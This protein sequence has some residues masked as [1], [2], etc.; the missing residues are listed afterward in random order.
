MP[1][2][3]SST[4]T[5]DA[6]AAGRAGRRA[7]RSGSAP[8]GIER[9]RAAAP[10]SRRI[11]AGQLEDR[12][13]QL[14][15]GL[16]R[17]DRA[18]RPDAAARLQAL[19]RRGPR[20]LGLVRGAA[21][22]QAVRQPDGAHSTSG[23]SRRCPGLAEADRRVWRYVFIYPNTDDRPLSGPGQRSGRSIPTARSR[24]A[25]TALALLPRPTRRC[26][27]RARPAGQP[28]GQRAGRA[29]RTSTWSANVQAGI[30][31]RGWEPG[32]AV[33]ARGRGR[34]V[35]RPH[36]RRPRRS[37]MSAD[38][39]RGP[40]PP[41]RRARAHPRRRPV[42]LIASD[43]IDDVRIARIAHGRRRLHLARPLPLRDPRG[44]ARAEAL[45]YSFELAGDVRIERGRGRRAD[46][47][48]RLARDDRPVPAATRARSSA[49]GS[50]G[51]SSGCAPCATPSCAR[52]PPGSTRACATGSPR[53][54]RGRG[55]A[56]PRRTPTP[57]AIADRL[58]AL[59]DGFGVR[60]LLGDLEIDTPDASSGPDWPTSSAF[61][62]SRRRALDPRSSVG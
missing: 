14:P 42:D 6:A 26:A 18:P 44:A 60:V 38:D 1:A 50:S 28:P 45:E 54:S 47:A 7:R 37:A 56:A 4:S 9:L 32:P 24:R 48:E 62:T 12:R 58:L 13:R 51:S 59:G 46:H 40:S 17:A 25:T 5:R 31:T 52:P 53:R 15:R 30:E 34:L 3:S 33:A 23:W 19:R 16:P 22:R 20:R 35:R 27:A 8:T 10:R 61:P 36:P 41:T 29:T 49:T 39:R 55:A 57:S 43:G 2:S 21:A 11:A